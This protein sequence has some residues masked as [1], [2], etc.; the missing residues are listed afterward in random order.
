LTNHDDLQTA[1]KSLWALTDGDE[2]DFAGLEQVLDAI[3][4]GLEEADLVD[5]GFE[6][7]DAFESLV[8][9]G[10]VPAHGADTV[11]KLTSIAHQVNYGQFPT[12]NLERA[13]QAVE[14]L[15]NVLNDLVESINE[16]S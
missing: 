8:E 11:S 5:P 13:K 1:L 4:S 9:D 15:W 10:R 6:L 16:Q 7:E 14:E 12:E 3:L 2:D